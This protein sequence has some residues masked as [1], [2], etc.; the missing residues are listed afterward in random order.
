MRP[1]ELILT[2]FGPYRDKECIDFRKLG[3]HRLFVI[4]GNTGAGKTTIFDAI[5]FALYGSASGEDRADARMLRSDFAP[6]DVH[7]SVNFTFAAGSRTYRVFRQMGHR[8]GS[9]KSETG[10][11]IELYEIDG[12]KETPCVDRFTI[13]DVNAKLESLV[14]LSKEQFSQI[15]MLPQG[16]FR[17]LL[18][19]DTEN[20]EEILR[21]IFR[22]SLYQR[23]E[24]RF[25]QMVRER[26]EQQ[27][28][29]HMALQLQLA[30][31]G[32]VLPQRQ[33]SLL[34]QVWLQPD[35]NA[36]QVTAALEEE[37]AYYEALE[38]R[39]RT[40][41]EALASQ[42][43]LQEAELRDSMLLNNRLDEL[44]SLREKLAVLDGQKADI[45]HTEQ[46]W[47]L[48][49]QAAKIE[50]FEEQTR[51]ADQLRKAKQQ[52]C[53]E[54]E[55]ARL[56]L[57]KQLEEARTRYL[58][59]EAREDE[60]KAAEARLRQ[61]QEWVPAVQELAVRKREV[62]ALEEQLTQAHAAIEDSEHK[63]AELR[64]EKQAA[65]DQLK[66]LDHVLAALPEKL[67]ALERMR[68]KARLL[69]ELIRLEEQM[70]EF[71]EA[72]KKLQQQLAAAKEEHDRLE[73]GWIEGQ[74]G[75]LAAHLHD[76]E[77]CPVCGSKMHP[78]KA[79]A[80]QSVPSREALQ[81]AK[82]ELTAVEQ[83]FATAKAEAAAAQS[84]WRSKEMDRLE[85]GI[86][87]RDLALQMAELEAEGK[88]LRAETETLKAQAAHRDEQR[89]RMEK[90]EAEL[91]KQQQRREQ[92][93]QR[94]HALQMELGSKQSLLQ[95]ELAR[96]PAELQSPEHLQA[97]IQDQ[98]RVC[99]ELARAWKQAQLLR[100]QLET[101]HAAQEASVIQLRRQA[102]DADIAWRDAEARFQAELVKAGFADE[103]SYTQVK[104]PEENRKALRQRLDQFAETYATLRAQRDSLQQELGD[105]QAVD[106]SG[107]QQAIV[108]T[109]EELEQALSAV[110]QAARHKADADRIRTAIGQK[111]IQLKE[112]ESDLEQV[113]DIHNM[114]KGD[115]AWKMS[116]ERYILI[117]YLEQILH[118]A[119][120]RLQQLSNGQFLLQ[121]SGRLEARG[122]QS[123]LGLDVFDAY[124]GQNR[125]VK[126]LSGGEKF[127][128]SLS[129]ALGMTDVIQAAQGGISIEMMLIDEGFGSLDEDS[130]N[131]AIA[132]L[133]DLQRSGRM[134]GVIS[135]VTELKQ[136]FPAVLEV[137]K[138]REGCSRTT[139]LIK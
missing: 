90:L 99:G 22:T 139:F 135:H 35:R 82:E 40:A 103:S 114:L 93:Q 9:N 72:E 6:E 28:E 113:M 97:Q 134:I 33:D 44:E 11:K 14:G 46:Q 76:G 57:Q 2:A 50:P 131:K 13:S 125:D 1:I 138:T 123:G 56:Y 53:A 109:K 71:A 58:E 62:Q 84:G 30:Q 115:N 20:K 70:S 112:V 87:P 85:Y 81:K 31:A 86:Q 94:Y 54:Q 69:K 108:R 43:Q 106:I 59:E 104:L 16:E 23:L 100:E 39:S 55:Q 26:K 64:S 38:E 132:A 67:A 79:D 101:Q 21:R 107:I 66:L 63:L 124:T 80:Q 88:N 91:D 105:R 120:L 130:L 29:V 122:R 3:N 17:K 12:E 51:R 34:A 83:V 52:E 117:E 128:A 102:E 47:R 24:E 78:M 126:T 116:F 42:L 68:H 65:A 133:A 15:V 98:E 119:N 110:Q 89:S 136:A 48:A 95:S 36:Q 118:A 75:L 137:V 10:S 5:S 8:K 129:L 25:Q 61:L 18:T 121:R 27:K 96:I 127:H 77:P 49:E 74:A 4:S 41:K 7:T 92:Q 45:E 111:A 73:T 32:E 60:R 37:A 19:S